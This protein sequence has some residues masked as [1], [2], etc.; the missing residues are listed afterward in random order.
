[1]QLQRRGFY[2]CDKAFDA[3]KPDEPMQLIFV[4]DGKQ[5]AM[6]TVSTATSK[7]DRKQ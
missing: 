1:V 4:P 2:R 7:V 6:S 3:S 5:K